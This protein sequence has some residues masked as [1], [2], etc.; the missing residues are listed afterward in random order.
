MKSQV[1]SIGSRTHSTRADFAIFQ[2]AA[3]VKGHR[4]PE[5]GNAALLHCSFSQRSVMKAQL[6]NALC[7]D[8]LL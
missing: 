6:K 7:T 4:D 8:L 3:G 2:A 5:R 1:P